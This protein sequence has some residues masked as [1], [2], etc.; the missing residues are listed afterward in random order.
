MILKIFTAKP[1]VETEDTG[2]YAD[3]LFEL[4]RPER[5]TGANVSRRSAHER[6]YGPTREVMDVPLG[7]A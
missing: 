6:D 2:T 4:N 7:F 1:E 3:G 5:R